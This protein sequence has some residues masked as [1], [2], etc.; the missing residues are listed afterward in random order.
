MLS[1]AADADI[2]SMLVDGDKAVLRAWRSLVAEITDDMEQ[3]RYHLA[4]E[5]I[6]HYIWHTF[7]DTVV[8]ESK[9]ALNGDDDAVK[10]SKKALLMSV[11]TESLRVLHPFMPFL[12]E[13]VW[14]HIPKGGYKKYDLIM[15]ESWPDA[16]SPE[17]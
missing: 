3:Y 6:Y 13:A 11:Y 12:T 17:V 14:V 16:I 10:R 1:E 2:D 4:G 5:K 9:T 8:E 15:I 7:A